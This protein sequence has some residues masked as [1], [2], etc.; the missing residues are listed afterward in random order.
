MKVNAPAFV[1]LNKR[2]AELARK[3]AP[4]VNGAEVHGLKARLP[5]VDFSFEI[6]VDHLK[7]LFLMF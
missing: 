3:I 5:D 6:T 7:A 1:V 2:G 4:Q